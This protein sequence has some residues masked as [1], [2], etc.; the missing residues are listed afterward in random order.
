MQ[1]PLDKMMWKCSAI[2][3]LR[4]ST[5]LT[6]FHY[7][8]YKTMS[9]YFLLLKISNVF[10]AICRTERPLAQTLFKLV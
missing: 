10:Y 3:D 2:H 7:L 6:S 8:I 1:L 5:D 4:Y 9:C